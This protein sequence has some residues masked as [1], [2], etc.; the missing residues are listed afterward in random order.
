MTSNSQVLQPLVETIAG[1][2]AGIASTL[3]AHPLDVLKTR[4]QGDMPPTDG[5]AEITYNSRPC[6]IVPIRLFLAACTT[7]RQGGGALKRLLPR[8]FAQSGRKFR[9]L[10]VI[11]PVVW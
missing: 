8:T 3:V 4:L 7:N 1:F 2:I 6:I 10:G 9:K 11:L 5:L